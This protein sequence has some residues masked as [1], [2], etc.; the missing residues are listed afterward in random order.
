M[1]A[2]HEQQLLDDV[3]QVVCEKAGYRMAWVGFVEHDE[4]KTIRPVAWAGAENGYLASANLTWADDERGR[5]PGG[6]SV[7]SGE[8]QCIQDFATDAKA[9]PWREKA[10]Q[11]GY[12]S[13]LSL[14]LKDEKGCTFGILAIYSAESNAFVPSEVRLLEDL[15]V[16]L[17][18][19][20]TNLC[21]RIERNRAEGALRESEERFAAAFHS[22]PNLIAITA[23]D[24]TMLDVNE[25][26]SRLLGYSR[27]D[28]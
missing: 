10:L 28:R 21:T 6:L 13:S 16:D 11:F 7:R 20:I 9:A 12:R 15:A 24:G 22:S 8:S 3:C 27:E 25:G 2:H 17:V 5:G 23:L 18:F 26:Y 19:G 1:R 14:P 4:A